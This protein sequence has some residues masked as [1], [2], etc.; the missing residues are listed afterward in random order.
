MRLPT[1]V[2]ASLTFLATALLVAFLKPYKQTYMNVCDT[3]LLALLTVISILLSR[4]YFLG[5]GTEVFAIILIPAAMF[6]LIVLFKI[7]K[8]LKKKVT[9]WCKDCSKR[10]PE[11][12][13]VEA[14]EMQPLLRPTSTVVDMG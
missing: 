6:K 10:E 4:N 7:L 5:D 13:E 1:F 3:L 14:E 9:K 12:L 2:F 11:D 8:R